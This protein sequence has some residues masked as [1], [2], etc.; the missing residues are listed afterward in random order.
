M[1]DGLRYFEDALKL[2]PDYAL[3]LAGL[4]DSYT[5][6]SVHSYLPPEESWLKATTAANHA[7][8]IGPGLAEVHGAT[9]AIAWL[10]ERNWNKAETEYLKA[11]ELNPNYLQARCWY[12]LYNQTIR[13]NHEEALK[14]A[15]IAVENDPL[16]CYAHTILTT[17]ASNAGLHDEAIEA[18]KRAIEFDRE[19][20]ASWFWLG[21][22]NHFAGNLAYAIQAYK[23][24]IDISGRHN[25]A[26]TA[27]LSLLMEPSEYQQTGEGSSLYRELLT[28]AKTGYVSPSLLAVASAASGKNEDAIQYTIQALERHDSL[29]IYLCEY[30]AENKSLR[31]IPE[32]HEIMKA[33]GIQ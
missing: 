1:F 29:Y 4:A 19:S 22:S 15:R 8:Q 28:K 2:D 33:Y 6:L 27:L 20:F 17:I 21:Y 25:W 23:K 16:S 24:A 11:M 5:M 32:F 18:A 3:A 12:A 31:A 26:L 9:A 30:R 14:N 10:F 13:H 7:I